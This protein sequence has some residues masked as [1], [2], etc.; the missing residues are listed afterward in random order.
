LSDYIGE[1]E[2]VGK[3]SI[4]DQIR[5][6]RI[7]FRNTTDFEHY[8][9]AIDQNYESEDG[10]FNGYIYKL[11]NPQFNIVNRSRSGN[12]RD[13]K[14]QIIEYH[15]KNCFIPSNG[16]CFIKCIKY[17]TKFD[18]KEQYL[19]FIRNEQRRSNIMTM[20]RIQPCL[21]K[22]GIDVGYYNG[23]EIWPRN[24]NERNQALFLYNNH[25][26]VIWNSEKVSFNQGVKELSI[27]LN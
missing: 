11:N 25:F 17:L 22:P 24:V 15:G 27:I 19:E 8:I 5:Q 1:F 18:Y 3:L 9:N 20:A 6:T 12:G 4:G 2:M 14:H 10:I 23:K 16:Y 26:C 21:R 7:R 13:F